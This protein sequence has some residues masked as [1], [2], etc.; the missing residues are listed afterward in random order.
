MD[1]VDDKTPPDV[2]CPVVELP[3]ARRGSSSKRKERDG[4]KTEKRRRGVG[5]Y[6]RR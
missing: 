1:L 5:L 6:L 2:D 4:K 3:N